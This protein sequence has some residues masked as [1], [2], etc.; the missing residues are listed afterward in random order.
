VPD[1]IFRRFSLLIAVVACCIALAQQFVVASAFQFAAV[2]IVPALAFFSAVLAF[3]TIATNS[4]ER[5]PVWPAIV[6]PVAAI[7]L[8]VAAFLFSSAR[9]GESFWASW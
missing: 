6:S 1:C 7:L 9:F 5:R 4:L 3:C 8:G 2:S